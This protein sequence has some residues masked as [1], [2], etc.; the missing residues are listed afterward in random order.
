M[1]SAVEV[2]ST[3]A[4]GRS[5][6]KRSARASILVRLRPTKVGFSPRAS[7]SR[8]TRCPVYPVAPSNT[9][10]RFSTAPPAFRRGTVNDY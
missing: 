3:S 8:S 2:T 7:S 9:I 4:T 5:A 6:S 1:R 10:L